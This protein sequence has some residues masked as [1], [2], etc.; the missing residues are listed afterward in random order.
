MRRVRPVVAYEAHQLVRVQVVLERLQ[1]VADEE[2]QHIDWRPTPPVLTLVL[3]LLLSE[4]QER[5]L[6][7]VFGVVVM[8]LVMVV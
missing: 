1:I 6:S 7:S 5:E 3:H 2:R 8:V 4:G